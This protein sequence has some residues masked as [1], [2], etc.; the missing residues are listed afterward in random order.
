MSMTDRESA[1]WRYILKISDRNHR[2][3]GIRYLESLS[4]FPNREPFPEDMGVSERDAGRI[5]KRIFDLFY[6]V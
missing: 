4:R 2:E 3:Y 1:A 5:R 6:P